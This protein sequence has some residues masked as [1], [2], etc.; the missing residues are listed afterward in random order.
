[1]SA[2][3]PTAP[4][5]L[6]TVV[7]VHGAFADGASWSGVIGGLQSAGST[8]VAP[9]NPLRG[10]TVDSAYIAA[11]VGAIPGPV[12]LVGHSY[13]GA[14]ITNAAAGVGNVVG[15]VY[16]AAFVPDEG[17]SLQQV[18]A[19]F[20]EM[21]LV[22]ALRPARVPVANT[23]ETEIEL[24]IDPAAYPSIV[25]PDLPR[26]ESLVRAA[27]QRPIVA[28]AFSA[29]SQAAAWKTLPSWYAVATA[30]QVIH[31]DEQRFFA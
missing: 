27:A 25:A 30:D 9:A 29:P 31:P 8:V 17:E 15:L 2:S 20:P 12:I 13:G 3:N 26:A 18:G 28:A 10:L 19:R 22:A 4:S 11:V 14:V 6:P 7:L 1:M 24:T 21:P 5:G 16:V 23:D